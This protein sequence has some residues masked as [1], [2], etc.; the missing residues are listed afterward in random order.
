MYRGLARLDKERRW[1]TYNNANTN[2]G[3]PDDGVKA[4]ALG[5][6][7]TVLGRNISQ[8]FG[9][10]RQERPLAALQQREH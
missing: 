1:Q 5:P 10:A 8:R 6:D 4:L 3:L 2:G 7:G 9:T